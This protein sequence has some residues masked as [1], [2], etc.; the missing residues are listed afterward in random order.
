MSLGI[1]GE[2]LVAV[3]TS[4]TAQ[5]TSKKLAVA[6]AMLA[7]KDGAPEFA[8]TNLPNKQTQLLQFSSV[9]IFP[10]SSFLWC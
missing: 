4:E 7:S 2:V 3:K 10:T 6:G 8:E 5:R 1:P 9:C